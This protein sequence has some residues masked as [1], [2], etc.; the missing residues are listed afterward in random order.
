MTDKDCKT[1]DHDMTCEV[2]KQNGLYVRFNRWCEKGREEHPHG[3]DEHE[4][5]QDEVK[6]EPT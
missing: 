2:V 4:S 3:C 5:E 6:N 1:C